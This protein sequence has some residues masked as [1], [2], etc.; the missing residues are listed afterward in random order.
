MSLGPVDK[1][2][3]EF[4]KKH[5]NSRPREIADAL[6][7]SIV[8]VRSSLYRLRERGYVARTSRGYVAKTSPEPRSL[9]ETHEEKISR[10]TSESYIKDLAELKNELNDVIDRIS[11]IEKTLQDFGETIAK[12]EKQ[13]NEIKVLVK[14]LQSLYELSHR[15]APSD[16]LVSKL[17]S[18]KI[19]SISEARKYASE[20]LG[21]L[22]KYI[23]SGVAVIIGKFVVS[24][25]F[26]DSIVAKLPIEA[27]K[28]NELSAKEKILIE[29]LINEGYAYIDPNHI[30]RFLE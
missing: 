4:L 10:E 11:E 22:D 27:D 6:G 7:F 24:K 9:L 12:L 17:L 19:L 26:Y 25:E 3:L 18:E 16:P 30:I 15:K 5:P 28:L 29:T 2:I 8:V 23:E 21:S 20:G 14:N 13:Y 1:T